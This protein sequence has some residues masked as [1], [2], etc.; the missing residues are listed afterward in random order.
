MRGN[1]LRMRED[2]VRVHQVALLLLL[3]ACSKPSPD[4]HFDFLDNFVH[5]QGKGDQEH[6]RR[7]SLIGMSEG[8]K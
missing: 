2:Q 8:G 3:S 5:L 7:E 6:R 1:D 4:Y